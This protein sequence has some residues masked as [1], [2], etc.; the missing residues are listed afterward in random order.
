MADR[1]ENCPPDPTVPVWPERAPTE[2][3][4]HPE[5]WLAQADWPREQV[6][7]GMRWIPPKGTA[8]RP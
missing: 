4:W 8:H 2:G 5:K 7:D 1:A 6:T 3:R